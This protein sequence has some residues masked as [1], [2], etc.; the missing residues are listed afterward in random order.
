MAAEASQ[1]AH[2]VHSTF[3]TDAYGSTK[4]C[5]LV[6]LNWHLP[7]CTLAL[8]EK[9]KSAH[10]PCKQYS[11]AS[12]H[13]PLA[14]QQ[15]AAA[16]LHICADGGANRLY[17]LFSSGQAAAPER[18]ARYCPQIIKGDLDSLRPEVQ[19]FYEQHGPTR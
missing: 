11:A 19:H 9:G 13:R 3:L 17:D 12:A 14:T 1:A 16:S 6:L 15:P 4:Q 2:Q 18:R 10:H 5:A 8:W 7:R